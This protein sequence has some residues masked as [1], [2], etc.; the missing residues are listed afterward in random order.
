[1]DHARAQTEPASKLSADI[2]RRSGLG[3]LLRGDTSPEGIGRR[4]NVDAVLDAISEFADNQTLSPE[5]D[6]SA[7]NSLAAYLQTISLLTDADEKA[8]DG[9]YIT[10][11]SV[12]AAK[13][14]EYR[15]IFVTGMKKD[16]SLPPCHLKI[17]MVWTKSAGCF[18]WR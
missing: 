2:L 17:R 9:E 11:M 5:D 12:H 4:E 1:M 15:S 14:L 16:F 7:A 3:D 13:G 8:D 10:L 6:A 18:M